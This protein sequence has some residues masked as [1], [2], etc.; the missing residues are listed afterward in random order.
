MI[1]RIFVC[2]KIYFEV[3][4]SLE[5]AFFHFLINQLSSRKIKDNSV[6]VYYFNKTVFQYQVQ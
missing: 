6:S 4:E 1:E 5:I 2:N 3:E